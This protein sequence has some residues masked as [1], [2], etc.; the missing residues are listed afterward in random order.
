MR[1]YWAEKMYVL[2]RWFRNTWIGQSWYNFKCWAWY[3][4]T[5]IKPRY[6]P[7]TYMDY[8]DILP[9]M[10][11]EILSQFLEKECSPGHVEW[12]GDYSHKVMVGDK[13]VFV[14]DEM[15]YLYNWW[16]TY[17]NKEVKEV[18][19]ILWAEAEKHMPIAR[20]NEDDIYG[21]YFSSAED[22]EIFEKCSEAAFRLEVKTERE[23]L[24]KMR[25][26]CNVYESM[27]T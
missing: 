18:Y 5:T 11:F 10:I 14:M 12:Y 3:R 20:F 27:W 4:H 23:L 17:Y 6:L 24:D 9:H 19:A 22:K 1:D 7:H 25:R 16:H 21:P 13:E 2:R 26:V 8:S 15:R